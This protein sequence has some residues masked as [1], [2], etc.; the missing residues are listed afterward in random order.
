VSTTPVIIYR[1]YQ[2]HR[3][4]KKICD[5]DTGDK[6]VSGVNDTAKQFIAGVVD[7]VVKHS[8]AIISTKFQKKSKVILMEYSGALR[9]LIHEN[10]QVENLVS[11]SL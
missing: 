9:T 8:V 11:D 4:S 2:R 1:R 3:R 10:K 6:F 7:T 5:K